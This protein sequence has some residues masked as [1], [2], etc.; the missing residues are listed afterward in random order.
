MGAI[1]I[2]FVGIAHVKV[3]VIALWGILSETLGPVE[4]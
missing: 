4:Q 1:G 3:G 2:D